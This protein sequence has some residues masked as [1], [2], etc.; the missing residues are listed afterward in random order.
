[1]REFYV[2]LY[3]MY[4]KSDDT[5]RTLGLMALG[6]R[7]KRL[8][9]RLQ[10]EA[11][12]ILSRV[13]PAIPA[14]QHPMLHAIDQHG[15]LSIGELAERLG[16]SQPGVTRALAQLTTAGLVETLVPPDDGR[17]RMVSLT[18]A[19]RRF[20]GTARR[21]A[22]PQVERA[23]ADLCAGF[24]DELLDSLD[25]MESGLADRPLGARLGETR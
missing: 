9:E 5:L 4:D 24:A 23:V 21:E 1:M 6:S 17:R 14:G 2:Q 15:P 10:T 8:G 3:N 11:Q 7:F 20:V 12:V 13:E 18:A 16:V 25:R 22:W 19:G